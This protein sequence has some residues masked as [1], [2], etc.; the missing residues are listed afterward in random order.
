MRRMVGL[1]VDLV[2]AVLFA[3]SIGALFL[4]PGPEQADPQ[5]RRKMQYFGRALFLTVQTNFLG[6][7]YF[8]VS[9]VAELQGS[10]GIHPALVTCFPAVFALGA[11]LTP[12]YYFLDHSNPQK[13]EKNALHK[14]MGFRHVD[15]ADH[16][17]HAPS[18]P[19]VLARA[20]T[21]GDRAIPSVADCVVPVTIYVL[22][23]LCLTLLNA[24]LTGMWTYPV[25]EDVDR[26]A[27]A[28]G[29]ALLFGGIISIFIALSFAAKAMCSLSL[30]LS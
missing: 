7:V 16:L 1:L 25:I 11:L 27:G 13:R 22:F 2:G 15:I 30:S 10:R 24:K 26:K 9:V 4:R 23:F 17:E 14:K 28:S 6:L 3:F 20:L 5:G 29:V 8:V 19:V 18:L 12:L 21:W